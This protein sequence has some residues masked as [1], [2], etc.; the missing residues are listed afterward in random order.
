[1]PQVED[2]PWVENFTVAKFA[3]GQPPQ[4]QNLTVNHFRN[5]SL[6]PDLIFYLIAPDKQFGRSDR[7]Y[8]C[9]LLKSHHEIIYVFNMFVNNETGTQFAATDANI[10]DAAS[11]ITKVY[12]SIV[13][14]E[15]IHNSC[16]LP[17]R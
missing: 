15:P 3:E 2:F 9:D 5:L 11:Q 7:K 8:L 16:K 1:M 10:T 17:N 6:K 14:K 13:G 12:T 4:K